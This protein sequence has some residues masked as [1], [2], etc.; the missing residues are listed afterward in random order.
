[1][2]TQKVFWVEF[3]K[4][5]DTHCHLNFRAFEN[6]YHEIIKHSLEKGMFLN[7][8]GTQYETS[9]RAVQ[10]AEEF[11]DSPV[12]AS[13]GLHPSHLEKS[14]DPAE[15]VKNVHAWSHEKYKQLW[16]HPKVAGI[17]ETGIDMFRLPDDENAKNRVLE[18]QRDVFEEHIRL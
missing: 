11:M 8:V 4:M 16:V 14:Y 17:G 6:D 2:S 7:I 12:Y 10:I 3:T 18:K 5:Y 13:V 1:M 9:R 15:G